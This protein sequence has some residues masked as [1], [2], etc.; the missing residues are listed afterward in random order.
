MKQIVI[1][2]HGGPEKLQVRETADPRPGRGEVRIRVEASGINFADI[3]TRKGL[4]PDAPRLPAVVG[5]E[6][7]GVADEVGSGVDR[8]L[9]G[10]DVVALTRFGGY[11]DVVSVPRNQV[12]EK[13]PTLSHVEAAAIPVSYLTAWQLLVVMG[14]LKP[15]ETVLIHNAGGGV[16]L[17]AIDIARHVGATIYGTASSA[18]HAFLIERG[19]DEAI[20]YRTKDWSIE[21]DR[22]TAGK[23]VSLITDPFGGTH[24]KKSYRALRSTGRL[25]MFGVSGATASKLPGPLRLGALAAGMPLFHPVPLMNSNRS[26]FGVNLGHMWHEPDMIADWM[27]VLLAGVAEGWVRPHVD[28][29]F[30]LDHAGDAQAYIEARRNTGK[31]VLTT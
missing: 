9:I 28:S 8:A 6:V 18:K 16:G 3:L 17:A 12:Y 13:P 21:V 24:W 14:S 29:T 22:L 20:D 2:G 7:S 4:Y 27:R 30:P 19:V 26:V 1:V 10:R 15:G 25:G 23:G 31:V 11:S 5:Y